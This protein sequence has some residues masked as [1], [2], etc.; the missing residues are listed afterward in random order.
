MKSLKSTI[1]LILLLAVSKLASAQQDTALAIRNNTVMPAY[2]AL[3]GKL[4][5]SDSVGVATAAQTLAKE[6]PRIHLRSHDLNDLMALK[7][8]RR[9]IIAEATAMGTTGNMNQQRKHFAVLSQKLW[10][11]AGRYRFIKETTV[12]Y[13]QCPMT[14]VTWMSDSK[15]IQNPYYPKNMLT[16]GEVKAAL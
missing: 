13:D 3:H 16:C 9:E 12:Y 6:L 11:L 7:I 10:E 1:I 14:G 5:K 2:L 15:T 4:I 8:L